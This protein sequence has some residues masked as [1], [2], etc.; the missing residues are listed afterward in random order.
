MPFY[1]LS[2]TVS[3]LVSSAGP[4]SSNGS[5]AGT[6]LSIDPRSHQIDSA[7][8]KHPAPGRIAMFSKYS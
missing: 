1:V 8:Q 3:I 5:P 6:N 2:S 4:A 7:V